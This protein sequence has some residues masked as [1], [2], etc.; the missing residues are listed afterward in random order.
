MDIGA[1]AAALW[2]GKG[3][4]MGRKEKEKERTFRSHP[5]KK[6]GILQLVD[7]PV[8]LRFASLNPMC[9]VR[10]FGC[11]GALVPVPAPGANLHCV[12]LTRA[13]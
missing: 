6:V 11:E 1:L 5:E 12:H 4:A 2:K 9:V 7:G 10:G 3:K 13:L 8:L